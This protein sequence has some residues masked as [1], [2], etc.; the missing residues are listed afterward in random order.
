MKA[1]VTGGAGFIGSALVDRLL[2]EESWQVAVIDKMTYAAHPQAFAHLENEPRF[3][4]IRADIADA[5]SMQAALKRAAPDLVFH[6]AAETHVDRS[7]DSAGAFVRTNVM[8]T[9]SLLEAAR[10]WFELMPDSQRRHF[11]FVHVSTDEVFGSLGEAG[12]FSEATPYD[13]SSPYSASKAGSDHLVRAWY[14]TFGL[15]TLVSN[16]SNNYGPRQFPEKLIPLMVLN[17]L[18]GRKLPVYG[19]GQNVRDWLFVDD[20]V[21]ALLAMALNGKPGQTYAVGGNAERTNLQVV[22]ALCARLD[23]RLPQSGPHARLIEFVED[24]PGHDLR[25]AI[26]ASRIRRELGWTPSVSFEEGLAATVDWYLANEAWWR[27][28]LKDVY[29][30]QRLGAAA[31][32]AP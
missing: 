12:H 22:E 10:A 15:P 1:L 29:D 11:R 21:S 4:L 30:G 9:Y 28:L 8:G 17:G 23:Q 27:P 3:L 16:C 14:R 18:R 5:P 24:R 32:S 20:H 19:N 25:Y 7:I 2:Q 6:L 26:D 31:G 13:P